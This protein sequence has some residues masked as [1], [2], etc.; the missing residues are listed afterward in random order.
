MAT[1]A[2]DEGRARARR[3]VEGILFALGLLLYAWSFDRDPGPNVTAH[4]AQATAIACEGT[5]SIDRYVVG[6]PGEMRAEPLTV[7]WSRGPD[8]RYFPAKAPGG[9]LLATPLVLALTSAERALGAD[10]A[11]DAWVLRNAAPVNWALNALPSALTLV[12]LLRLS[13]R[14][15]LAEGPALA[16]VAA[17]GFGT[18]CHAYATTYYAHMPAAN[19]IVAG[20]TALLSATCDDAPRPSAPAAGP[21]SAGS[22][23]ARMAALA[24]LLLGLAVL[25]DYAAAFAV[26]I[27]GAMLLLGAPRLAPAFVLGG[28]G[29]LAAFLAYH[30]AAFGSPFTTAYAHQNPVFAAADGSF[31]TWP[32]PA[33]RLS[34]LT[35]SPY[36]GLLAYSPVLVLAV[37]GAWA[38]LRSRGRGLRALAIGAP[39]LLAC[40]LGLNACYGVWWG[41]A[42]TGPR[43][44]IPALPLLA[45]LVGLGVARLPRLGAALLAISVATYAAIAATTVLAHEQAAVPLLDPVLRS[46]AH[47]VLGREN[48][49]RVLL[50]LPHPWSL[51]PLA[52]ASTALAL[53]LLREARPAGARA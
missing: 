16:G 14:L 24:G 21:P 10:P 46:L 15:G 49:G 11:S 51:A 41:G 30:A 23:R 27:A 32:P 13:R 47:G 36:R 35:I 34:D 25:V 38:A 9:A 28:V 4:V 5:L 50:G 20:A 1:P 3:R 45:P 42:T 8:G 18:A 53:L 6:R 39:A 26:V 33:R 7:D 43:F 12:L 52:L 19:L 40:Y 44:P 31:T 2:D 48:M 17:I 22:A 37:P 29:P